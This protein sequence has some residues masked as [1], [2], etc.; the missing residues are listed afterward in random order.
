MNPK[1]QELFD[2]YIKKNPQ[3][4]KKEELEFLHARRPYM[5]DEQLRVFKEVFDKRDKELEERVNGNFGMNWV[6]EK[7]PLYVSKK[8]R[9][10]E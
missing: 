5:N 4:L 3:D 2:K 7:P 1:A 10:K 8:D 9:A 6:E